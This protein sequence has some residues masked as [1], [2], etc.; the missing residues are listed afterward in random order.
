MEPHAA[1]YE[2][3][4]EAERVAS[5][6]ERALN[7]ALANGESAPGDLVEFV[8]RRRS[9]ATQSLFAWILKVE[10]AALSKHST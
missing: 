2:A 9:D 8:T 1:A 4:A 5:S 6:A 3:W 7:E 10:E